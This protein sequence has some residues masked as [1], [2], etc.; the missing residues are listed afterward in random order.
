MQ[1]EP[2]GLFRKYTIA[3][4][5]GSPVADDFEGFVLRL[6]EAAEPAHRAACLMALAVYAD[7]IEATIPELARDLRERYRLPAG[8]VGIWNLVA[9]G[10]HRTNIEKG[11]GMPANPPLE[12]PGNQIAL[13]HGELSEAHEAIRKNLMDDKLTSRRGE[14][15]ELADV[16]I[17][18][19][20]YAKERGLDVAS[21]MIEKAAYNKSRPYKH[22]GKQF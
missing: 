22:G 11:F 18:V 5:D 20:N 7:A 17:R 16:V 12:W 9:T 6:D 21:A 10:T 15:V 8:L 19:M 13:M 14:E 2:K 3:K 1:N 4:A